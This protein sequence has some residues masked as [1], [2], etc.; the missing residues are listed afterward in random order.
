MEAK[1]PE[2]RRDVF[3][4]LENQVF[5]LKNITNIKENSIYNS[6]FKTKIYFIIYPLCI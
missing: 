5:D 1:L 3:D 6:E 2:P 4:N